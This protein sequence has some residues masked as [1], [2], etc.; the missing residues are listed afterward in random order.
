MD[1]DRVA[2]ECCEVA[3]SSA[4][5]CEYARVCGE[6]LDAF[7]TYSPA[8]RHPL[9][10]AKDLLHTHADTS[11]A[12]FFL[13]ERSAPLEINGGD[14]RCAASSE[15]HQ[16]KYAVQAEAELNRLVATR[17]CEEESFAANQ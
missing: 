9:G 16:E 5:A 3:R 4:R 12:A 10:F 1:E 13:L 7:R 14:G 2:C 15:A 6:Y 17:V 11:N 8:G